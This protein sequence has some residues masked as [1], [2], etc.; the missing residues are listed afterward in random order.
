MESHDVTKDCL[1]QHIHRIWVGKLDEVSI[2]TKEVNHHKDHQ[3]D[4]HSW[5]QLQ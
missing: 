2:L 1:G 5:K 3:I 4:T